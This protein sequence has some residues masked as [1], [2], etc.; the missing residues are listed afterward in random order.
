[1]SDYSQDYAAARETL[2][3]SR[4]VADNYLRMVG[5]IAPR[6]LLLPGHLGTRT[7]FQKTVLSDVYWFAKLYE[8]I[9][10][11][12]I[13]DREKFNHAGFV[14]HFIPVFYGLYH[15][16]IKKFE[17]NKWAETSPLWRVHFQV[18]LRARTAGTMDGI[19][20]SIVTGVTAH[21]KGDMATA[22]A[23]AYR[24][25]TENPKPAFAELKDDFFAKNRPTFDAAKA[26]FFLELQDKGPSPFRPEVGQLI[27]GTGETVIGGGLDIDEVYKWRETAWSDAATALKA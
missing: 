24:T 20:A 1:M 17:A 6:N 5:A 11:F 19:T 15:S 23:D 13:R 4:N 27:I 9:T 3:L 22:L 18:A 7:G 21:V 8:L 25:W 2:A 26:A 12:E 10:Y 16:A 14:M